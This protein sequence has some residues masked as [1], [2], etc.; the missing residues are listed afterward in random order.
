[1]RSLTRKPIILK[2]VVFSS[3]YSRNLHARAVT[4]SSHKDLFPF[5]SNKKFSESK[6]INFDAENFT[7]T[8]M[9]TRYTG[10]QWHT[11]EIQQSVPP[12]PQCLCPCLEDIGVKCNQF[13]LVTSLYFPLVYF[14][15]ESKRSWNWCCKLRKTHSRCGSVVHAWW[16]SKYCGNIQ[17]KR[18]DGRF[19]RSSEMW[20]SHWKQSVLQHQ[21]SQ[22]LLQLTWEIISLAS[23]FR[24]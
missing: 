18:C 17:H 16:F 20:P 12:W 3:D 2:D 4:W 5:G 9:R 7:L 21:P 8:S 22:S 13:R 10:N 15:A 11:S 6:I 19:C 23:V 24:L 14:P 1:L